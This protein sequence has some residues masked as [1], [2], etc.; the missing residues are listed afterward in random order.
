MF[1]QLKLKKKQLY[2]QRPEIIFWVMG[3][4]EDTK[5]SEEKPVIIRGP[6]VGPHM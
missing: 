3:L 6:S 2:G 4:F 1:G 5:L